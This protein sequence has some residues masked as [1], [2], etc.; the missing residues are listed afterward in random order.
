VRHI[1]ASPDRARRDLAFSPTT[2]FHTG[3]KEL[4]T[5]PLRPPIHGSSA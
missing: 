2:D 5:A 4:A 1:V 3:M